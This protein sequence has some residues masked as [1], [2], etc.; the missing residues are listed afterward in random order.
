MLNKFE[1]QYLL[2]SVER[3]E[4]VKKNIDKTISDIKRINPRLFSYPKEARY[5]SG[6]YN[7][8]ITE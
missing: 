3:L 6:K 4:D 2:A 8:T 7:S 5:L 1:E